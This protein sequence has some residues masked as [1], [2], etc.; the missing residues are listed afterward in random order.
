M[1]ALQCYTALYMQSSS[2]TSIRLWPNLG[3][4]YTSSGTGARYFRFS[5]M[6]MMYMKN[7]NK[8]PK[9]CKR[10][11]C[12]CCWRAARVRARWYGHTSDV[13]RAGQW[14][15]TAGLAVGCTRSS[16]VDLQRWHHGRLNSKINEQRRQV[17]SLRFNSRKSSKCE[18]RY[19][20]C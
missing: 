14:R 18:G 10:I 7:I 9:Q 5:D 13:R 6:Y 15:L 12:M 20:Q 8:R 3:V 2:Q 4:R 19:L 16:N 17:H 11:T 1:Y